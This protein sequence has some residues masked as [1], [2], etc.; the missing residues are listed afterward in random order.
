[1]Q[2]LSQV[3]I[4][5]LRALLYLSSQNRQSGYT[6]IKDMAQELGISF[7]FLTKILQLLTQ[8]GIL[9]SYRG[10]NGG[11]ALN[12]SPDKLV[13]LDIVYLFEGED[14]FDTCLLGLPGC[15]EKKPCP[16]HA[17]WKDTKAALKLEFETTTLAALG[18]D[19]RLGNTR[20]ME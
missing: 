7:H 10:P 9:L 18:E 11:V 1:M 3:C 8:K 17:F 13:L 20:L 2:V 16:V 14:F 4:N 6:G 19:I 5:G 15:G 12:V